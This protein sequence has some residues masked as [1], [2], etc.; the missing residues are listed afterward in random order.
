MSSPGLVS[1]RLARPGA[2]AALVHRLSG[3]ALAVFLPFH[4][5][6]LGL[7]LEGEALDNFLHWAEH[8]AVKVSEALLVAAL[9]VHVAG[10]LR[11][12]A[13]EF[14]G[15]MAT[16]ANGIAAVFGFAVFAGML[17]LLSAFA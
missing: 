11:I 17:F 14:L 10:G 13:I 1:A 4:F 16:G 12:L 7:A 2:V 5:L 9:A 6:S 3:L 8:P 15:W